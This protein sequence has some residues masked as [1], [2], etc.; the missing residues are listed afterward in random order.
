[1]RY[2][3]IARESMGICARETD[4]AM[5]DAQAAPSKEDVVTVLVMDTLERDH[6]LGANLQRDQKN[7]LLYTPL[8]RRLG[9]TDTKEFR[10]EIADT[11]GEDF[12]N[13][14]VSMGS[15]EFVLTHK[16]VTADQIRDQKPEKNIQNPAAKI[17]NEAQK[18]AAPRK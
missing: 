8:L 16:E 7:R 2:G 17:Q 6:M 11:L 14:Q 13:R 9:K 3:E 4:R 12:L 10:K 15:E 18:A 5:R 1:M